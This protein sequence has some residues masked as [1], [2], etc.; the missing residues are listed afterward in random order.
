[1]SK[2]INDLAGLLYSDRRAEVSETAPSKTATI[3]GTA[4]GNSADGTVPVV[5]SDNVTQPDE[6]DSTVVEI[7]TVPNVVEGDEVIVSLVG[8]ELKTPYVSGVVGEGDR[9]NSA[10]ETAGTIADE[11]LSIAEAT[12]QHFWSDSNGAHVTEV[13]QEEWSDSSGSKYQTGANSLW[14]SLG[15]LFRKGL[16]NLMAL[17][18]DD[19]DDEVLGTTGVAIFDGKDNNQENIVASFTDDGATIGKGDE[20]HVGIM[21]TGMEIFGRYGKNDRVAAIVSNAPNERITYEWVGRAVGDT[22][23]SYSIDTYL[24][25]IPDFSQRTVKVSPYTTGQTPS[26]MAYW[27]V[28][29]SDFGTQTASGVTVT[30]SDDGEKAHLTVS[31]EYDPSPLDILN[32]SVYATYYSTF[33][34]PSYVFGNDV[35]ASRYAFAAGMSVTASGDASQAFGYNV[36]ASGMYA[37]AEGYSSEATGSYSHAEGESTASG[38]GSHAEGAATAQGT[39]THAEGGSMTLARG[40]ACHAE[41]TQTTAKGNQ[42]HAEGYQSVAQGDA[43]HA[44]NIGTIANGEGQTSIGKWNIENSNYALIIGNGTSDT[45]RSN[46]LTVDWSGDVDAA[47][48][49]S[50]TGYKQTGG[51]VTLD[52]TSKAAW[53]TALAPDVLYEH[54]FPTGTGVTAAATSITLSES[55]ANYSYMRIIY[56]NNA[57][58]YKSITVYQPNG[59]SVV[60][61]LMTGSQ[62]GTA[63]MWLKG[64]TW[65]INGTSMTKLAEKTLDI[66]NGGASNNVASTN[67]IHVLRVEA[68]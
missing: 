62:T 2:T 22:P 3:F 34:E 6:S 16:T 30:L 48:T 37:H 54:A 52:A 53:R 36:V 10:I 25:E 57:E 60:L 58:L 5:I 64:S 51:N 63:T 65:K 40:T 15:M 61:D 35:S 42:C 13:T 4:A 67:Q 45:A 39:H 1:M 43:A 49:V 29:F 46:A 8:G 55:A 9:L 14:N 27:E 68:W 17:V 38:A 66:A 26:T 31:G 47:G 20:A 44:Q 12:N 56:S 41:G 7:P 50:D 23:Y 33:Y 21:P 11:A 18:V 19:P 59:K 28:E 24:Q 32:K